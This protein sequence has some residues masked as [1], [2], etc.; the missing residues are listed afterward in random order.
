MSSLVLWWYGKVER[1]T[2]YFENIQNWRCRIRSDLRQSGVSLNVDSYLDIISS[3]EILRNGDYYYLYIALDIIFHATVVIFNE[4]AIVVSFWLRLTAT[5]ETVYQLYTVHIRSLFLMCRRKTFSSNWSH[6]GFFHFS[7]GL[8]HL[9]IICDNGINKSDQQ[10]RKSL[11]C[12][13]HGKVLSNCNYYYYLCYGF[14]IVDCVL[15][16]DT[17]KLDHKNIMRHGNIKTSV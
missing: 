5:R 8:V 4:L 2:M 3:R 6:N 12:E 9:I 17:R 14:W 15:C 1:W 11:N 7:V 16:I 13:K 10:T